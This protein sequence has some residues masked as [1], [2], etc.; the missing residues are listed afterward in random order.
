MKNAFVHDE[1]LPEAEARVSIQDRSF[2]YGD[3]LFETLRIYGGKPFRWH[4]HHERLCRGA[5]FLKIPI[6]FTEEELRQKV[7]Q[8]LKLNGDSEALLRIHLSR[9][10]GRRGYS[11]SGADCP[12][13]VLTTH[14]ATAVDP[15]S[16]VCWK[17]MVSRFS[18]A[19]GDVLGAHKTANKL[20][21]VLAKSEAEDQGCHEALLQD[22]QGRIVEGTSSNVF[23]I[24]QDRLHTPPL[25]SAGLPGVTREVVLE[26][27]RS[28]GIQVSERECNLPA[29]L[30]SEGVF[31]S[32]STLEIVPAVSLEGTPLPK[33]PRIR[34]LHAAYQALTRIH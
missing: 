30:N 8:L 22:S 27:A 25:T 10:V 34:E 6:R 15:D 19:A 26:L 28:Q 31:L 13:L 24:H 3:G 7:E 33:N 12:T 32:L 9:G 18:L 23:W 16:P 1:F 4:R 11:P 17:L 2:L 21:H 5:A 20:L 14:P 29:L